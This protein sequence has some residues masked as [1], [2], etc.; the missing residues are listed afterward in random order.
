[1]QTGHQQIGKLD[2]I[3]FIQPKASIE[4]HVPSRYTELCVNENERSSRGIQ[5]SAQPM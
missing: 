4:K 5:G 3:L 1:M 2:S